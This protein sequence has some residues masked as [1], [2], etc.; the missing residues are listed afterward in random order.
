MPSLERE[1]R[2]AEQLQ[3]VV[4]L[5]AKWQRSRNYAPELAYG[6]HAGPVPCDT[7]LGAV[8][9]LF[10]PDADDWHVVLTVRQGHLPTH[11]GQ[12][13][14]PGGR[15]EPQETAEL[16]A[17]REYTEEV[18]PL[19]EFLPIGRLPEIYVFAS[20]F[21]VTP[22][23]GMVPRKPPFQPNANE[24]ADVFGISLHQLAEPAR[25]VKH[26]IQRGPISFRAPSFRIGS[27]HVWGAT[28][29][30]LG[31]LLERFEAL[32]PLRGW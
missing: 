11:A 28:W 15:I 8:L 1:S 27:R 19:S 13:S 24:V 20:R 16:A 4:A 6:R 26:T 23:V 21:V 7:R 17:E 3:R 10:Y 12:V 32:G 5:P 29:M 22:C 9:V 18:G 31:D 25:Q 14:F 30:I 2:F